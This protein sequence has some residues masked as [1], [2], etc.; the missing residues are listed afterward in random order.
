MRRAPLA[1]AVSAGLIFGACSSETGQSHEKP[2]VP[3]KSAIK[4]IFE[5]PDIQRLKARVEQDDMRIENMVESGHLH[6]TIAIGACA[7]VLDRKSKLISTIFNPGR[8][9]YKDKKSGSS[10]VQYFGYSSFDKKM[11]YAG[12]LSVTTGIQNVI[13]KKNIDPNEDLIILSP[14]G[15]IVVGESEAILGGGHLFSDVETG[16][17]VMSVGG[18][19]NLSPDE[20]FDTFANSSLTQTICSAA[21]ISSNNKSV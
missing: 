7:L 11:I 15:R 10:I 2:A 18:L 8:I 13:A 14:N 17:F 21:S 4:K 3:H 5:F 6:S 20:S 1:V 12:Q 9:E 19:S 16:R